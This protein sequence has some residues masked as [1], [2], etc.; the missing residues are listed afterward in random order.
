[1]AARTFSSSSFMPAAMSMLPTA[2]DGSFLYRD[3]MA[4]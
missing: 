2:M 4:N 3:V 1:M